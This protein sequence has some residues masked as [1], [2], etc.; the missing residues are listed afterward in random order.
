[1][2]KQLPSSEY[3]PE[4]EDTSPVMNTYALRS[5]SRSKKIKC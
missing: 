5:L 3:S 4:N 2:Y 1:M